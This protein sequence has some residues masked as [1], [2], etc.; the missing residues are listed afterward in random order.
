MAAIDATK[1]SRRPKLLFSSGDAIRECRQKLGMSQTDFWRPIGVTQSGGCRYETGRNIPMP[2]Q[3]I[4][5]LTYGT[6]EQ[7]QALL[8]WLRG[9]N[10]L[11]ITVVQCEWQ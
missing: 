11:D 10:D 9:Q 8:T 6:E 4:L 2:L 5:H 3:Q 1:Q 7:A